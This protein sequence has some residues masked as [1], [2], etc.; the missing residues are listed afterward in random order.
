M[1]FPWNIFTSSRRY[2]YAWSRK[3][4]KKRGNIFLLNSKF[5]FFFLFG[6]AT[7]VLNQSCYLARC[8]KLIL[9]KSMSFCINML[10]NSFLLAPSV[11]NSDKLE[12]WTQMKHL[13]QKKKT[14]NS[15]NIKPKK[16]SKW[17]LMR[18]H[19]CRASMSDWNVIYQLLLWANST[20]NTFGQ[21]SLLN[22]SSTS[23]EKKRKQKN[24]HLF[25]VPNREH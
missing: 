15:A 13:F 10:S 17:W 9:T 12:C 7:S 14:R 1:G 25:S 20:P 19:T 23:W 24:I 22:R 16:L 3:R 5:C 21:F 8:S 4:G 2:L 11:F 6:S 18:M